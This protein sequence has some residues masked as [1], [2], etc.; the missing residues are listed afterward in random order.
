MGEAEWG[1]GR[2][3]RVEE[4]WGR[5]LGALDTE[6]VVPGSGTWVGS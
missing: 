5:P 6:G 2:W 4:R 1:R 3:N